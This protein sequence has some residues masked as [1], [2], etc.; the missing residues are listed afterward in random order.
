METTGTMESNAFEI[1]SV[2]KQTSITKQETINTLVLSILTKK[3]K[4]LDIYNEGDITKYNIHTILSK[5]QLNTKKKPSQEITYKKSGKS[6]IG[7]LFGQNKL[8]GPSLQGIAK[9]VR[10]ALITGIY[11]DFDIKNCHPEILLQL[12][13]H[14]NITE[15]TNLQYYISN[16]DLCIEQLTNETTFTKDEAK[17]NIIKIINGGDVIY[18]HN[19]GP[20]KWFEGLANEMPTIHL[21]LKNLYKFYYD[22]ARA[23]NRM[24]SMCNLI[25][26]DIENQ[27]LLAFNE[28]CI[29]QNLSPDVLCFDGLMIKNDELLNDTNFIIEAEKYINDK[30]K[31]KLTIVEKEVSNIFIENEEYKK[32]LNEPEPIDEVFRINDTQEYKDEKELFEL[33]H[34]KC[35]DPIGFHKIQDDPELNMVDY[36]E[37][38]LFT[39]YR[40]KFISVNVPDKN[41]VL[42]KEEFKFLDCSSSIKDKSGWLNDPNMRTY[43]RMDF[44]PPPNICP[45]NVYNTWDGFSI[46]KT[47]RDPYLD[48]ENNKYIKQYKY[49][50]DNVIKNDESKKYMLNFLAFIIQKPGIKLPIIPIILG[51]QGCGKSKII[52]TIMNIIGNKYWHKSND[53]EHELNDNFSLAGKNKILN[54]F[55]ET[56]AKKSNVVYEKFKDLITSDTT[57]INPK[58]KTPYKQKDYRKFIIN[59]NNMDCIKVDINDRRNVFFETTDKLAGPENKEFWDEYINHTMINKTALRAIYDYLMSIDISGFDF[60]HNKPKSDLLDDIKEL[61]LTL[62]QQFFR[63]LCEL[64]LLYKYHP[65]IIKSGDLYNNFFKQFLT[66]RDITTN[67]I[68]RNSFFGKLNSEIRMNIMDGIKKDKKGDNPCYYIEVR[69][70]GLWLTKK[71]ILDI[72]YFKLKNDTISIQYNMNT[73]FYTGDPSGPID[74]ERNCD[75]CD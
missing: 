42:H 22:K 20:I 11:R 37:A 41:G 6:G 56:S 3:P 74:F 61:N 9:D 35:L 23:P 73:N 47:D 43:E 13:K 51:R 18:N 64:D 15:I 14:N 70:L 27:C 75:N 60:I 58:N 40:N 5:Y 34:F 17:I 21:K 30:T 71:G 8:Y 44:F 68:T 63:W 26:T 10:N 54:V 59:S 72:E 36:A 1:P 39:A 24:G 48:F 33:T 57:Y 53:M 65:F 29:Q 62:Y 38:A 7:R 4:F 46:E 2:Y 52:E 67:S 50:I 19:N 12:C 66:N 69:K 16:R 55:E 45:E 28:Y 32:I 31:F 25:L 49:I